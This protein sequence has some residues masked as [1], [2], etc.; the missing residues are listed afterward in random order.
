MLK[1]PD[2][3]V[4]FQVLQNYWWGEDDGGEETIVYFC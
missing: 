1:G 3:V 2:C 4:L